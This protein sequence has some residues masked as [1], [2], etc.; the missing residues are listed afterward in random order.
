MTEKTRD[1]DQERV[2]RARKV[3]SDSERVS[4]G[5]DRTLDESRRVQERAY[6]VLK[7]AGYLRRG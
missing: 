2:R 6:P 4:E 7:R 1:L 5:I 3:L